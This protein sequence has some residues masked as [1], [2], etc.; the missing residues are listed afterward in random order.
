MP[1][2][3]EG[4]D[5]RKM[6]KV[7]GKIFELLSGFLPIKEFEN[8]LYSDTYILEALPDN[9]LVV[10]LM[11]INLKS[12]HALHE[13]EKYCARHFNIEKRIVAIVELNCKKFLESKNLRSAETLIF[14]IQMYDEWEDKYHLIHQLNWFRYDLD[15][16]LEGL[17]TKLEFTKWETKFINELTAF[18]MKVL[19][20]IHDA[21]PDK[22]NQILIEGLKTKSNSTL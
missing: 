9:E 17:F 16:L 22:R 8:W 2:G 15:Q 21:T 7:K 19:D 20:E 5:Q 6:E 13:I 12:V 4:R 3:K 11:C 14:N 1:L 10:E 18:C